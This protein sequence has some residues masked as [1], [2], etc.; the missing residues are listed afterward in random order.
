MQR[1]EHCR[2]WPP[3]E[4]PLR[5]LPSA[6]LTFWGRECRRGHAWGVL[7]H[8]HASARGEQAEPALPCPRRASPQAGGRHSAPRS[9]PAAAPAVMRAPGGRGLGG[10]FPAPPEAA[11]PGRALRQPRTARLGSA[12]GRN[13]RGE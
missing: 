5:P 9:Q 11:L 12:Q 4:P 7:R 2:G 1:G 6:A 13:G 10:P 3:A 8:P